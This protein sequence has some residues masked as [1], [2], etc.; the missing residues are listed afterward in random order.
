MKYPTLILQW[1]GALFL[2]LSAGLANAALVWEHTTIAKTLPVGVEAVEVT[3]GFTNMGPKPVRIVQI[4]PS[5][6]CTTAT[7]EKQTFAPGE[8]G[9]LTAILDAKGFT[10][11]QEKTI[12]VISDD[13]PKP[14][15]LILRVTIP[16][17]VKVYPRLLWWSVGEET[18][19]KEA[20]VT[21]HA[22]ADIKIASVTSDNPAVEISLEP[23]KEPK[24]YRLI[25]KPNSTSAPLQAKG[26][27]SFE[28]PGA[29]PRSYTV[30]L[31]VR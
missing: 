30:F 10:G 1:F 11:T 14:T 23:G 29:K 17:L 19:A 28:T 9:S 3:F 18:K 7:M 20:T 22:D 13:D 31:Q 27:I 25:A 2:A 16:E 12:Q 26:T 4:Q 6:G 21:L 5:C 8:K 24:H 15:T